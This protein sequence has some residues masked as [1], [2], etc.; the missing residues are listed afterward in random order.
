M[1]HFI[2]LAC[3]LS[4]SCGTPEHAKTDAI[5]VEVSADSNAQAAEIAKAK[6]EAMAPEAE[7]PPVSRAGSSDRQST[8]RPEAQDMCW[9]GYCPCDDMNGPTDEYLC[10]RLRGGLYVT[11]DMFSAGQGVHI[12]NKARIEMQGY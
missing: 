3:A 2:I 5:S 8:P 1:K 9:Q 11:N 12:G 10:A 4:A 7:P 6:Q